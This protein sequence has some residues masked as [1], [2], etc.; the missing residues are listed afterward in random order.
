MNSIQTLVCL[1]CIS[2]MTS[3]Y[4]YLEQG[5]ELCVYAT[6]FKKS[7]TSVHYNFLDNLKNKKSGESIKV[8]MKALEVN[9]KEFYTHE[10]EADGKGVAKG[11]FDFL[12]NVQGE[13]KMCFTTDSYHWM[14]ENARLRLELEYSPIPYSIATTSSCPAKKPKRT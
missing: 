1:L 9:Q 11:E 13:I 2:Q 5:Q 10:I 3:F 6:C 4:F 14:T 8:I 12:S 7:V